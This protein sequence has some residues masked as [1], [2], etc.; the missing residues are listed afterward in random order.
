M[1]NP[2][3][4]NG[5]C[6]SLEIM[7]RYLLVSEGRERWS[8][9]KAGDSRPVLQLFGS[10]ENVIREGLRHVQ[11]EGGSLRISRPSGFCPLVSRKPL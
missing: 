10:D 11:Q 8:L 5:L 1:Q 2:G 9:R 3:R 7:N 4:R 6:I